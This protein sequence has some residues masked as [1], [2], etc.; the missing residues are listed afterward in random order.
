MGDGTM[1]K[2]MKELARTADNIDKGL[3]CPLLPVCDQYISAKYA[4]HCLNGED[5]CSKGE[6]VMIGLLSDILDSSHPGH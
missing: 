1:P 6:M 4:Y 2:L 3:S 5:L